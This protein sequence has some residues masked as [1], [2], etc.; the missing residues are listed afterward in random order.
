MEIE[1][2]EKDIEKKIDYIIKTY[3]EVLKKFKSKKDL[4]NYIRKEI[5]DFISNNLDDLIGSIV[6]DN[7]L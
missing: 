3:P 5:A 4:E 6:Y 2:P 7:C 1:I